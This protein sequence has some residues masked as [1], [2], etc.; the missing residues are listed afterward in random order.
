[1]SDYNLQAAILV[2]FK[3]GGPTWLLNKQTYNFITSSL[4][5]QDTILVLVSFSSESS[6]KHVVV[7]FCSVLF[8]SKTILVSESLER[9]STT[10]LSHSML[11]LHLHHP[12][13][14]RHFLGYQH[15]SSFQFT[16]YICIFRYSETLV[17][18]YVKQK[19]GTLSAVNLAT[20]CSVLFLMSTASTHAFSSW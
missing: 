18:V 20:A 15:P 14:S 7:F 13:R 6:Y 5:T 1:M 3:Y 9:T 11:W 2:K 19:P 16:L 4:A 8:I 10:L 17:C 12:K